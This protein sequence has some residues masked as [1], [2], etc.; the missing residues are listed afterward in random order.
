[1]EKYDSIQYI[2]ACMATHSHL[3]KKIVSGSRQLDDYFSLSDNK[4]R[5]LKTFFKEYG[6]RFLATAMLMEDKRWRDLVALIQYTHTV[7]SERDLK[8]Y[9]YQ[10]LHQFQLT[11]MIPETSL[12]ES[13]L[14][15]KF[16]LSLPDI[17]H[18]K[19]AIVEYELYKNRALDFDFK[20]DI[21]RVH[22]VD[23]KNNTLIMHVNPSLLI[24]QFDFCISKIIN[25]I[26]AYQS[27]RFDLSQIRKTEII[28]FYKVM[29]SNTIQTM[30]IKNELYEILSEMRKIG[31][32][33][34]DNISKRGLMNILFRKNLIYTP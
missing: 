5:S 7:I 33:D 26:S 3:A 12:K 6:D 23:V 19:R 1:M 28:A 4:K 27:T 15:L 11:S 34:K 13:I 24:K 14:F 22:W 21:S 18:V 29:K 9:W 2:V 30:T 25:H 16:L 32:S 31:F 17:V 20:E 10:Y 8:K